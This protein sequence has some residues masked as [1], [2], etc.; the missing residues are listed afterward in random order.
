MFKGCCTTVSIMVVQQA[1]LWMTPILRGYCTLG[2]LVFTAVSEFGGWYLAY[3]F[4]IIPGLH[5]PMMI[6][7]ACQYIPMAAAIFLCV[8]YYQY[9]D[10]FFDHGKDNAPVAS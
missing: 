3:M 8:P 4:N 5:Y 1:L 2:L 9:N 7:Q 6:W 10:T